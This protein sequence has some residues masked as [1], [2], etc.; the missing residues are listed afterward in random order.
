MKLSLEFLGSGT[1]VGV[2]M[3]GCDCAVCKSTDPLNKRLRSSVLVRGY[4]NAGN[5]KTTVVIDT[6]PD[7]RTQMLRA[8]VRHVDAVIIT[9][10]HADHVVG[11]DD[12]RRY[13]MIQNAVIDCWATPAT[14]ESLNR[15]F[16]YIFSN[17]ENMRYGLPGLKPRTI[18]IGEPFE[19]GCIRFEPM[20]LDHQIIKNTGLRISVRG[21]DAI[22]YCLD[23]KRIPPQSY[24]ALQG[25]HTLVLDMLREKT[26]L[27]HMNLHEAMEAIKI[28]QP[29][30]T[31]F[32]HMSHEVD[33]RLFESSLPPEIRLAYDGLVIHMD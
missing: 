24:K 3:I 18:T 4:D 10:F 25:T 31:W 9:H 19:I 6:S 23:V 20:E 2:P 12:I 33:H 26:H 8:D 16:G 27:T 11:I 30:R 17:T 22:S 13:N 32:G 1:S 14:Q 28:I 29:K 15:S 5:V 21:G 7:F